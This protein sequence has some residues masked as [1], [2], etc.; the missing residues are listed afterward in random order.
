[1]SHFHLCKI[2][3]KLVILHYIF[4]DAILEILNIGKVVVSH[5]YFAWLQNWE[6]NL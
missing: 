5:I 3:L 2:E 6:Q 4:Q 1:M